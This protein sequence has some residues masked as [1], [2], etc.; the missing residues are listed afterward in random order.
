MISTT[1]TTTTITTET[2]STTTAS[3]ATEKPSSTTTEKPDDD[4]PEVENSM[5]LD[6]KIMA[7]L[8]A[9][10]FSKECIEDWLNRKLHVDAQI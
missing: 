7:D 9:N 8:V 4:V 2:P 1:I 5:V 10:K 6:K 3:T